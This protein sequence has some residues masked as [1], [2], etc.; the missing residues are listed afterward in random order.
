MPIFKQN[1]ERSPCETT[2]TSA[3]RQVYAGPWQK[4]SL[5]PGAA[6]TVR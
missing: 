4:N 6:A 2:R 3:Q 5:L 1:V